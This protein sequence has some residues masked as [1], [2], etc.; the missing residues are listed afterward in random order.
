MSRSNEVHQQT[1]LNSGFI[2]LYCLSS[3]TALPIL[4][5]GADSLR[6]TVNYVQKSRCWMSAQPQGMRSIRVGDL[7][8]TVVK[9]WC[10]MMAH[11]TPKPFPNLSDNIIRDHR[12]LSTKCAEKEFTS[13]AIGCIRE[14]VTSRHTRTPP[15]RHASLPMN[16]SPAG[17]AHLSSINSNVA[18]ASMN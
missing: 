16:A 6:S 2:T 10:V 8:L 15:K 12:L 9:D 1:A 14:N 5:S 3:S 17:R 13:A 4:A 18:L 7:K 11:A